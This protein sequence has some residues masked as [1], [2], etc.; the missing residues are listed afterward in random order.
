MVVDDEARVR[1]IVSRR[2]NEAGYQCTTA[3]DGSSA[4]KKLKTEPI[5]L[6]L[7]DINMPGKSGVEVLKE[8]QAKYSDVAVIMV[9]AIAEVET[10]INT[11]KFGAY[12]YIIKPI[13]HKILLISADKA[14]EKR[15]LILEN[16][17]YQ[18][19]L[20]EKVKEQTEKIR[21]SFLNSVTSL[22]NALEAKDIYTKGHSERVTRIA[23]A[24]AKELSMPKKKIEKI[25]LAGLLHDIGKIGVMESVLNKPG[26]LTKEEFEHIKSHCEIGQRI[27]SPIIE[28]KE[29]LD[30]VVHHHERYDG[31]GY[32]HRLSAEQISP[33]AKIMAVAEAYDAI[34]SQSAKILA[35][36]D[37]Y[38]AMTS[39][40]PYRPAI[41]HKAA[42][43][44]LEKGKGTQFDPAVVDAFL[45]TVSKLGKLIEG[46][47]SSSPTAKP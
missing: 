5:D 27:L 21:Q 17:V 31:T 19:H 29:I 25:R 9:T 1:E 26:K 45:Q 30:I 10:A 23:V 42:C 33:G 14:L 41:S 34:L 44:K 46:H 3:A 11:M 40:R 22:A 35:V 32:P 12:D 16:R 6:V 15:R 47:H 18:Q 36:A 7:L 20:E 2:L 13:D 24:V 39:D 38:D 37:A 8:I 43:A 4:L 28:D